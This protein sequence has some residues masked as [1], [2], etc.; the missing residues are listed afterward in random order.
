[1]PKA[2]R[3][4]I[5]Y[6]QQD[7]VWGKRLHSWLESYR[8]PR[9]VEVDLPPARR[10][11]RFFRDDEEMA[12]AAD[13]AVTVE[14]AIENAESLI[15]VCSP[16]SAKSKW[17]AAEIQHFRRT[18]RKLKRYGTNSTQIGSDVFAGVAIAAGCA[19]SQHTFFINQ[20]YRKT[21]K[22]G[23]DGVFN[24]INLQRF[25]D[26][27]IKGLDFGIFK[28]IVQRQHWLTMGCL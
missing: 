1:M 11:G 9:G 12:A 2:Y 23:F 26:P 20:A 14:G 18:G 4:F 16:R 24:N 25:A 5:S 19:A 22:F 7:A 6:S 21:V 3:A 17:V 28:G 8:V 13:I 15:V 10:L 27:A